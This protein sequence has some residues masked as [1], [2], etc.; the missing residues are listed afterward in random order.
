MPTSEVTRILSYGRPLFN[1]T[2]C[3]L[4][5][6]DALKPSRNKVNEYAELESGYHNCQKKRSTVRRAGPEADDRQGNKDNAKDGKQNDPDHAKASV[7][8]SRPILGR[9]RDRNKR[10]P[11][12]QPR[13]TDRDCELSPHAECDR[14]IRPPPPDRVYRYDR[15]ARDCGQCK[16]TTFR[17]G[18]R[19]SRRR[20]SNFLQLSHWRSRN[21]ERAAGS[22]GQGLMGVSWLESLRHYD[23]ALAER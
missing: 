10:G 22:P 18:G 14:G 7:K 6:S 1:L 13:T 19:A 11:M 4:R 8:R 12:T 21:A 9:P 5:P 2:R 16:A 17:S 23:S 20:S 3:L 15:L